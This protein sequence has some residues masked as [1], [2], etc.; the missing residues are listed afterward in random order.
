MSIIKPF[1]A[2]KPHPEYFARMIAPPYDVVSRIEAATLA[3][4]NPLSF[5]HITKPEIDLPYSVAETDPLVY[6]K[7]MENLQH[8]QNQGYLYQDHAPHYY[9]YR[10]SSSFH[11]QTG[12]VAAVS[13][14]A[15]NNTRIRKHE[16]TREDKERDRIQH[17]LTLNAAMSPV[18]LTY[19]HQDTI[20][21]LLAK[22]V[23]QAPEYRTTTADEITHEVWTIHEPGI[24]EQL[25]QA[26]EAVNYFYI[27]DGHHR[28]AAAAAVAEIRKTTLPH[29]TGNHDYFLA[30]LFPDN[31]LQILGYHRLLT[32]LNGLSAEAFIKKIQQQFVVQPQEQAIAPQHKGQFGLYCNKKWY[33]IDVRA[34]LKPANNIIASLDVS[35]LQEKILQPLLGIDNPRTNKRLNFMGGD[36]G[37]NKLQACVDR[38]EMAACFV[39]HPVSIQ[40][41][42]TV[43]DDAQIMPP[44][45]TWFTPKLA[46]GFFS[47]S[48][49]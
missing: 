20:D 18:L 42:F 30:G 38:G 15:Y 16:L 31:Q 40:D 6:I 28:S 37:L 35:I 5:L 49:L 26:F 46:D 45:S 47:L 44:K 21:Q 1:A 48:L 10:L 25:T 2:I 34:T 3:Q 14:E 17:L 43:S 32:D 41:L 33:L 19:R 8:L 27:A 13:V 22:Y 29:V 12:L 23:T 4:N 11:Q 36:H 39:L 24:I 9:I 7:G